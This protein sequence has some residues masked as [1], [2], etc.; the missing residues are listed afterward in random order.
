MKKQTR[1]HRGRKKK[2]VTQIIMD[3]FLIIAV[4][5]FAPKEIITIKNATAKVK[6][7]E[8]NVLRGT[9]K[10][11]AAKS[12]PTEAPAHILSMPGDFFI[13]NDV[14]DKRI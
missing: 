5:F 3:L 12:A 9:K 1:H 2:T 11:V 4:V 14:T 13:K 6:S 8:K 10:T 7:N